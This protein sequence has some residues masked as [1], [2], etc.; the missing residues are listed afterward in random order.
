[1]QRHLGQDT[2]ILTSSYITLDEEC[3][4]IEKNWKHKCKPKKAPSVNQN[5][6]EWSKSKNTDKMQNSFDVQAT[7]CWLYDRIMSSVVT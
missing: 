5:L 7:Y 6:N 4:F 2:T 1:M 3:D